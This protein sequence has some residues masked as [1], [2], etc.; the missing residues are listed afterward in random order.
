MLF[1]RQET[2]LPSNQDAGP[3]AISE[4][5]GSEKP[6]MFRPLRVMRLAVSVDPVSWCGRGRGV[7]SAQ[8]RL[9]LTAM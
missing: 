9:V 1:R 4:A 8:H 3:S 6:T 7:M 2:G 5:L